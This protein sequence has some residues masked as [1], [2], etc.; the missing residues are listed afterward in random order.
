[1]VRG[2]AG[3]WLS[4]TGNGLRIEVL[5]RPG[6]SRS[7]CLGVEARGLVM[8]LHAPPADGR[9]NDELVEILA[10]ILRLPR[11]N[12]RI[13]RGTSSRRKTIEIATADPDSVAA[14]FEE[15]AH[16]GP[17]ARAGSPDRPR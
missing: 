1:M 15:L 2:G 9:A 4:R 14:R 6:A 16:G 3:R 17:R 12:V 7:G 5:A 13:V 8:A 10:R 11:A